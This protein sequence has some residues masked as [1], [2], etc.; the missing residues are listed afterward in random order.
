MIHTLEYENFRA[1]YSDVEYVKISVN[2]DVSRLTVEEIPDYYSDIQFSTYYDIGEKKG[3]IVAK[4]YQE[5]NQTTMHI[6]TIGD[7]VG[8]PEC[9]AKI[10][11]QEN[12]KLQTLDDFDKF[13]T[14]K[15]SDFS[16]AFFGC[17]FI[18]DLTPISGWNMSNVRNISGMFSFMS[19]LE[20]ID[21]LFNWNLE[22][23][24]YANN[25]FMC[26]VSLKDIGGLS[27]W[28]MPIIT[29]T[30]RMFYGCNRLV[31]LFPL[32]FLS[33]RNID[34]CTEMFQG[35]SSLIDISIFY[36]SDL[37]DIACM[38]YAFDQCGNKELWDID[39]VDSL[40]TYLKRTM[41]SQRG[42]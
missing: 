13:D 31:D 27:G 14:S 5:F 40:H 39:T 3:N 9:S 25:L 17:K 19:S 38:D 37:P 16:N 28:Y 35:C 8:L 22:N 15:V 41:K 7:A 26:C 29:S 10:F 1:L 18:T 32:S 36:G 11:S 12:G 33:F 30:F 42:N 24:E 2:Y 4:I 34:D 23:I 20:T 21:P 6:Y